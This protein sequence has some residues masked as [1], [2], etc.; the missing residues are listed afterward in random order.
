QTA[1]SNLV[2]KNLDVTTKHNPR[3]KKPSAQV[4]A[5]S[6]DQGLNLTQN[7]SLTR[8]K[9]PQSTNPS[10]P[11]SKKDTTSRRKEGRDFEDST[12]LASRGMV[13][14]EIKNAL[15]RG[16]EDGGRS[17][18][19]NGG[20]SKKKSVVVQTIVRDDD[21]RQTQVD[22]PG[23]KDKMRGVSD[24]SPAL[25][26]G[27]MVGHDITKALK[28][29][30]DKGSH[31]GDVNGAP[32]YKR[33]AVAQTMV[34]GNAGNAIT[35]MAS[36]HNVV[37][38]ANHNDS[39]GKISKA[40][41]VDAT[42][43]EE[44][45]SF[46]RPSYRRDSYGT[47]TKGHSEES[48]HQV[49]IRRTTDPTSKSRSSA[50]QLTDVISTNTTNTSRHGH[51]LPR[52]PSLTRKALISTPSPQIHQN[53]TMLEHLEHYSNIPK[54]EPITYN[55]K[56]ATVRNSTLCFNF[57]M[58]QCTRPN[59]KNVHACHF[60]TTF[61]LKHCLVDHELFQKRVDEL[62]DVLDPTGNVVG[63]R[64]SHLINKFLPEFYKQAPLSNFYDGYICWDY[65]MGRC[66][67]SAERCI[68]LHAC[69]LCMKFAAGH[70][71]D[72]QHPN[73]LPSN[74]H[75]KSQP[76]KRDVHV[77]PPPPLSHCRPSEMETVTTKTK[78]NLGDKVLDKL[79]TSVSSVG[80]N[81]VRKHSDKLLTKQR[82]LPLPPHSLMQTPEIHF[83]K[84]VTP[85]KMILKLDGVTA[86]NL[87]SS[88]M[89]P[90]PSQPHLTKG[91]IVHL[92]DSISVDTGISHS[93]IDDKDHHNVIKYE[94]SASNLPNLTN[95]EMEVTES[96]DDHEQSTDEGGINGHAHSV[97][98]LVDAIEAS[99]PS[100]KPQ[101]LM[102]LEGRSVYA[103]EVHPPSATQDPS[104]VSSLSKSKT[105]PDIDLIN[106]LNGPPAP[107]FVLPSV[108]ICES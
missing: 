47:V 36:T 71:I 82:S 66:T 4:D 12:V 33:S 89:V 43:E 102:E 58:N 80:P 72:S 88:Y 76:L 65:N 93:G 92:P 78:W 41:G 67:M 32:S 35:Q 53:T 44:P 87:L 95:T 31:S 100:T 9:L 106:W 17:E 28:G 68:K 101:H 107:D 104:L 38:V 22:Q 11:T 18:D 91:S 49:P 2:P 19:V 34:N 21:I 64:V 74:Q 27:G 55:P 24:S 69:A 26:S 37:S 42:F 30:N 6:Y 73:V 5:G 7:S 8:S 25:V 96:S 40:K 85:L 50:Q 103:Q 23:K 62:E 63:V 98:P 60:C 83:E 20:V 86:Q 56:M 14:H 57:N 52:I 54:P 29:G 45:N 39:S 13:S 46:R 48:N 79:S 94:Q 81:D 1:N 3:S 84:E 99:M 77:A 59:C 90:H 10:D 105:R 15:K 97:E 16:N 51:A 75:S 70:S 108:G 61:A